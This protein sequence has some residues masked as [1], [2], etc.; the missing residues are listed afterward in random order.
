MK[1]LALFST[2]KLKHKQ[3][4]L[5]YLTKE[6][7]ENLSKKSSTELAALDPDKFIKEKQYMLYVLERK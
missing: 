7:R 2:Q 1:P 6:L 3:G 4:W 5:F